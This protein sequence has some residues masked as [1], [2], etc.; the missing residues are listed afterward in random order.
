MNPARVI[1]CVA[2]IG[3]L[4]TA[5]ERPVEPVRGLQTRVLLDR[6]RARVGEPIGVTIEIDTP[7]GFSVG[8]PDVPGES[9]IFLTDSVESLESIEGAGGLRHRVL[10]TVRATAVG[11]HA[12]PQLQIPLIHPDG[13][14]Q[15]LPV[16]AIPLEVVSVRVELP[17]RE[18]FFD[19]QD[20]PVVREARPGL[21]Y[22]G[23]AGTMLLAIAAAVYWRRRHGVIG[24]PPDPRR[25][26]AAA[27]LELAQSDAA[28]APRD[29]ADHCSQVVWEFLRECGNGLGAGSTPTDL[30]DRV[31]P[32][33]IQALDGL[34]AARFSREPEADAVA[35][36][37]D[38]AR[39][40]FEDVADR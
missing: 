27:L 37:R 4:A 28:E 18:V 1:V 35:R 15:A 13:R 33:L 16:G 9:R 5:C 20:P 30:S 34:D 21:L 22:G 12:L 36:C 8:R 38:A 39:S 10:W 7:P 31:V 14:I 25:L 3:A 40:H 17:D 26:A 2:A 6:S 29:R 24:A 32:L 23:V 11:Q 19:L